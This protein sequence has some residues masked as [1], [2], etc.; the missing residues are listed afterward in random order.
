MSTVHS[1]P[2]W[3]SARE[4]LPD[5]FAT[6]L[7]PLLFLLLLVC[8]ATTMRAQQVDTN[9]YVNVQPFPDTTWALRPV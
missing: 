1:S 8:G 2:P 4:D 7:R 6:R 5:S 3:A 9:Q